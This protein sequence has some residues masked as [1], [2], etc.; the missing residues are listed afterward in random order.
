MVRKYRN[1]VITTE[2]GFMTLKRFVATDGERTHWAFR[3]RDCKE[4]CDIRD[5]GGDIPR[6]FLEPLYI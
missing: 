2:G 1:W 4:F 5:A 6:L 3:L